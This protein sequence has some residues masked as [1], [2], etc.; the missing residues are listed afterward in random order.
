MGL[1]SFDRRYFKEGHTIIAGIDEAGRGPWAGPVVAAAV[2]LPLNVTIKWLRDSKQ[3]V[4]RRREEF[5]EEISKKALSIGVHAVDHQTIDSINILQATHQAMRTALSQ[6]TLTPGL[7]LVDGLPVPELGWPN[8]NIIDG[9][10]K[11]ACIAAASIIAKVTRDR[12]MI[13]LSQKYP[14]YNFQKNKGY[15]TR[16]HFEA[17]KRFGPCPIHRNSFAPVHR[18][19]EQ[20]PEFAEDLN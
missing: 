16:E 15:G 2:V 13:E 4:A 7:A 14:Q 5:F 1:F 17:L 9:D 8:V 3:L 10:T 20:T 6:I 19:A 11:S 18:L 12:L